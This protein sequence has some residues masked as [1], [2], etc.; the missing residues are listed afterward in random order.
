MLLALDKV[1]RVA[2]L[3]PVVGCLV[4]LFPH[5][6]QKVLVKSL[7]STGGFN[8]ESF[9]YLK[10]FDWK[11]GKNN[12]LRVTVPEIEDPSLHSSVDTK[13]HVLDELIQELEVQVESMK[14]DEVSSS[15]ITKLTIQ[16]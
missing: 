14:K 11:K 16:D 12:I 5:D 13:L 7:V 1:N 9:H 3:G 10:S 8:I 6:S 15:V 4:N 2:I